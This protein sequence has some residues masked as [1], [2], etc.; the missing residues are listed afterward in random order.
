[1]VAVVGR[2]QLP[3]GLAPEVGQRLMVKRQD[4]RQLP[5]TVTDVSPTTITI[6]AN[7]SLAG[8]NLTFEREL[9]EVL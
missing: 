8:R 9:V 4:G 2:D 1:M 7:H 6:D 3:D 5:V